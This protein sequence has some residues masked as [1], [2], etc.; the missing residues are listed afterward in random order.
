MLMQEKPVVLL[1]FW[2]N[3]CKYNKTVTK[4]INFFN[5]NTGLYL[6]RVFSD[7]LVAFLYFDICG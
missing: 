5:P 4:N 3:G 2:D 1:L 6:V 7:V